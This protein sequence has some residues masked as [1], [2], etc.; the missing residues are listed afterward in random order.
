MTAFAVIFQT[1]DSTGNF[2]RQTAIVPTDGQARSFTRVV[3]TGASRADWREFGASTLF[4]NPFGNQEVLVGR[5]VSVPVSETDKRDLETLT[6]P[7]T[8]LQKLVRGVEAH[9]GLTS[10]G[11]AGVGVWDD[12]VVET[13]KGIVAK[14][15]KGIS[16]FTG[17]IVTAPVAPVAPAPVVAPPVVIQTAP[18]VPAPV[19]ETVVIEADQQVVGGVLTESALLAIPSADKVAGYIERTIDG[20]KETDFYRFAK[21]VRKPVLILGD[22]GTGKT[23]SARHVAHAWQVP[24]VQ[25]ECTPTMTKT[26]VVGQFVPTA[27]K[28]VAIWRDSE[29]VTAMTQPSVILLNEL[30]RMNPKSAVYLLRLLQEREV[31]IPE[32]GRTIEAHPDCLIIADMNIGYKGTMAQDEALLSRFRMKIEF[33][34]D[35]DIESKFIP[36]ESLLDLATKLRLAYK[37]KEIGFPVSTR[38]L[39]DFVEQAQGLNFSFAVRSFVTNFSDKDQPA[40]LD[41]LHTFAD[42]IAKEL[43]VDLGSFVIPDIEVQTV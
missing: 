1:A 22:A 12:L 36:S 23:S 28:G 34:Y 37:R 20:V 9:G 8:L 43:G 21:S 18:E 39:Q 32:L 10:T 11:L 15:Q 41:T 2:I 19:T 7:T 16:A 27:Q 25:L 42:G 6:K 30:S 24:F 5:P 38:A 29:L 31:Y 40:V 4:V 17:D 3:P 35:R 14:Y 13:E 33:E 26:E